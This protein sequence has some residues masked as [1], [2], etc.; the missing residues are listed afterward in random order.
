[1][2]MNAHRL[3]QLVLLAI[4]I[5]LS[6]VLLLRN[7][8]NQNIIL[9]AMIW[10]FM[11]LAYII[12][13]HL[14]I[15][16]LGTKIKEQK[17]ELCELHEKM[18]SIHRTAHTD[19]LTGLLNLRGGPAAAERAFNAERRRT[20]VDKMG[21]RTPVQA[22][23]AFIDLDGFKSINDT[24]GHDTGDLVLQL[25]SE[26]LRRF[27]ARA[28]DTVY[29][30]G[31]DEFVVIVFGSDT[32]ETAI[33]LEEFCQKFSEEFKRWFAKAPSPVTASC[34]VVMRSILL[35]EKDSLVSVLNEIIGEAD[36]LMY[37]AKKEGKD[38]IITVG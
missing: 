13:D 1:M 9:V 35:N 28:T 18:E 15:T 5:L 32:K 7:S 26:L 6:L 21:V 10:M 36:Q 27:F 11:S 2:K 34:G 30:K 22:A 12:R 29:R 16:K 25:A 31:G 4:I 14:I 8:S 17:A 20:Y 19:E 37:R 33:R 38:Q 24:L 23:V 3:G